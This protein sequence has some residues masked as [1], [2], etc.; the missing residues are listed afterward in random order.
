MITSLK[1]SVILILIC[2]A[3]SKKKY[4]R[5]Q[6]V[7]SFSEKGNTSFINRLIKNMK[8][9][10]NMDQ[11]R[12]NEEVFRRQITDNLEDPVLLEGEPFK[13]RRVQTYKGDNSEYTKATNMQFRTK[14]LDSMLQLVYM[15]R[16]K[17]QLFESP[18]YVDKN[19]IAYRVGVIAKKLYMLHNKSIKILEILNIRLGKDTWNEYGNSVP[20]L[21]L[22]HKVAKMHVDFIYYYEVL[23][24]LHMKI[25]ELRNLPREKAPKKMH[26]QVW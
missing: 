23:K 14:I 21:T 20:A 6:D 17:L 11:F 22:H 15:A 13:N 12:R 9:Y 16:H 5:I 18:T 4:P 10:L 24:R 26:P 25:R 1:L 2:V 8:S 7:V 19:S 3:E